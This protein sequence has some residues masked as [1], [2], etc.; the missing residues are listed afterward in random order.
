MPSAQNQ[1]GAATAAYAGVTKPN[2]TKE[3]RMPAKK[4]STSVSGD[5]DFQYRRQDNVFSVKIDL[6]RL[7]TKLGVPITGGSRLCTT[8]LL[9]LAGQFAGEACP[10]PR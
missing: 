9:M 1:P 6:Q 5:G 4:R 7:A 2:K 3:I 10:K 8:A